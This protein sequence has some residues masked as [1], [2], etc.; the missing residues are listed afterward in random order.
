MPDIDKYVAGIFSLILVFL[1]VSRADSVNTLVKSI[2]GFVTQETAQ[3]QGVS[4][5][6]FGGGAS[7]I[8]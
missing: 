5:S 6:Q 3:L 7:L 2:G 8:R 1:L 4:I